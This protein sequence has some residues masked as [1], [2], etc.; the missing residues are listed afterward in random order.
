M[1]VTAT[2]TSGVKDTLGVVAS[3]HSEASL[4]AQLVLRDGGTCV[5]AAVAAA[6]V[7]LVAMPDRLGFGG[8]CIA[9]YQPQG[10]SEPIVIHG[11][12]TVPEAATAEQFIAAGLSEVP[13]NGLRAAA[14][15]GVVGG[16][17][18]CLEQGGTAPL[19]KV[20]AP[21][22]ELAHNGL[23]ATPAFLGMWEHNTELFTTEW[24][25][26]AENVIV[27]ASSA[28]KAVTI[29]QRTLA[30]CLT[31]WVSHAETAA[32]DREEQIEAARAA[33][34]QGF[35]AERINAFV[36]TASVL[37]ATGHRTHG[38]LTAADLASWTPHIAPPLKITHGQTTL[39]VPDLPT[40]GPE[41]AQALAL[42]AARDITA[43]M[44]GTW[45]TANW[46]HHAIEAIKLAQADR[47]AWD[48]DPREGAVT[49]AHL[50]DPNYIA[51]RSNC[52]SADHADYRLR[53][54]TPQDRI[55]YLP[56]PAD[57]VDTTAGHLGRPGYV[58]TWSHAV[59][60]GDGGCV[61][62]VDATGAS[63]AIQCF[64]GNIHNSPIIP[65]LGFA[66]GTAAATARLHPRA[67][68]RLTP[69]TRPP[70]PAMLS[71]LHYPDGSRLHLASTGMGRHTS[72]HVI[73]LALAAHCDH[74]GAAAEQVPTWPL[75][76]VLHGP[77]ICP[78]YSSRLGRVFLDATDSHDLVTDLRAR[79][80][81]VQLVDSR[82]HG[83]LCAVASS[84]AGLTASI[85]ARHSTFAVIAE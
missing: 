70:A 11:I 39:H 82:A 1:T 50:L 84:V 83:G 48:T 22:I 45:P 36:A 24:A 18:A 3:S 67:A 14:V 66:L 37:D 20:L 33:W 57:P 21:A 74:A 52:I 75:F 85:D 40:Q 15:P 6:F 43:T 54:G 49:A 62:V 9:T 65:D 34:Y 42:I 32:T 16:L 69:R 46:V 44:D 81:D 13:P 63:L 8:D 80:H 41:V 58:T 78:P 76:T 23:T 27:Q 77:Q 30:E 60:P 4:A 38:F 79:G 35:I 59:P 61:T 7:L 53:A 51:D 26:T 5:D 29:V 72:W 55:A 25:T 71:L 19:R 64:G 12:G 73:A 10:G 31:E 68:A 28:G 2:T 17:L 47:F 56:A